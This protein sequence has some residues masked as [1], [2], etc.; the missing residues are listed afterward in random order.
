MSLLPG[1][2]VAKIDTDFSDESVREKVKSS[3]EE[4]WS[5][6][7]NVGPEQLA[8]GIVFLADGDYEEFKDL[9]TNF[10]GDPRDLLRIANGKLQNNAYWFSLPF[11]RMGPLKEG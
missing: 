1:D 11:D 5:R 4:L 8:R 2:V 9:R 7:L 10:C 6:S 3:L